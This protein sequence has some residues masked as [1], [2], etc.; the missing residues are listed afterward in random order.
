MDRTDN[1]EKA[2]KFAKKLRLK[3]P[4]AEIIFYGS[5]V[6]NNFLVDSDFDFIIISD[7][8]NNINFYER[9]SIIYDIWD[10]DYDI[11]PLCYT[12]EEFQKKKK[13][14]SIVREALSYGIVL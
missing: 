6:K 5:R 14:I 13:Q 1:L 2:K 10:E 8:F 9:I 11:E 3:F 7:S 12:K 4:N